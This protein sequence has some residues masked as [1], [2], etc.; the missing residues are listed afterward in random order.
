MSSGAPPFTTSD[1]RIQITRR[2]ARWDD[3]DVTVAE[4]IDFWSFAAGAANVVM[5]LSWPEV[6]HGVAESTVISGS[7]MHHPWK[8]ARTTF[9]Y[10][11]S[12]SSAPPR[13]GRPSGRRWTV[14]TA[15]CDPPRPAR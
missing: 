8:R 14:H 2:T 13:T 15:R 4:A 12:R 10:I 5:Q 9:S 6:G 7:T 1:T 11:A 3:R